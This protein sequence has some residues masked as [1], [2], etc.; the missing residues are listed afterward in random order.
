MLFSFLFFIGPLALPLLIYGLM[1][2]ATANES[3]EMCYQFPK[4]IWGFKI[5]MTVFL[6]IP[7][8][9][10]LLDYIFSPIDYEDP[11]GSI[12]LLFFAGPASLGTF[13][14]AFAS[15]LGYNYLFKMM[16]SPAQECL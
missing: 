16:Y 2:R 9:I 13:L 10:S 3:E 7:L 8:L 4:A 11:I 12:P 5:V 6:S 1:N 14:S 15:Y